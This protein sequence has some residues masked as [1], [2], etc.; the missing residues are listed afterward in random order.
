MPVVALADAST[1]DEHRFHYDHV[2]GTSLDL[3]V[4]APSSHAADR[5]DCAV[6]GEVERLGAILSTYDATS[7]ISRFVSGDSGVRSR[8]LDAVLTAYDTWGR[9]TGG[10]ISSRPW[11]AS[12]PLNVDAIGKAYIIDRAA[13]AAR[14]A[15]PELGGLLLNIGGDIVVWGGRRDI[16]IADPAAPHDNARPLTQV[17]LSDAA[18]ATSGTYT[19]GAHIVDPRTARAVFA[20]ASA[21]VVAGDCVTANALATALCVS[22]SGD[23]L[24]LV[25]DTSGA[26]ALI[27]E[28]DGRTHRSAGFAR[29]ERPQT[30]KPPVAGNWPAGYEVDIALTVTGQTGFRARRPYVAIWVEDSKGRLVRLLA[31]WGDRSKY[32]VDLST[33]WRAARNDPN[34]IA[35]VARATRAPGQYR[36]V[37]DGLDDR[38]RPVPTG[39]YRMTVE[40]NQ[41]HGVYGKESGT[42]TCAGSPD[43]LTLRA[44]DDFEAVTIQ[45]GRRAAQL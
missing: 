17:R 29:L 28:S 40:A 21:T 16:A 43:T 2:L 27:V 33:L 22:G 18:I 13:E 3:V 37:W 39:T 10:L 6:R 31:V 11:G 41:E 14:R 8:D 19:R 9:R 1:S 5:A 45:Y 42:I 34:L 12:G 44:T 7:E 24:R 23:G 25:S 26:D 20:L 36:L 38:G 4:R 30:V 15:V 32:L 35:S